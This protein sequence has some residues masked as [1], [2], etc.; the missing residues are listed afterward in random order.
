M[1]TF[2]AQHL[3]YPTFCLVGPVKCNKHLEGLM[4]VV[5]KEL[6]S[7]NFKIITKAGGLILLQ[8]LLKQ[9]KVPKNFFGGK[10][11]AEVLQLRIAA[12]ELSG[13]K[14]TINHLKKEY[15]TG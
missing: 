12:S 15:E 13:R 8:H 2:V 6:Q 1:S 3:L 5:S 4:V 14:M 9:S 10:N 7:Q 11:G